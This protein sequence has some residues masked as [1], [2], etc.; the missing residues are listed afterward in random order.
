MI[1]GSVLSGQEISFFAFLHLPLRVYPCIVVSALF[2]SS[3]LNFCVFWRAAM[4]LV[5]TEISF[6][7]RTAILV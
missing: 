5:K 4:W 2:R 3:S 1:F 7:C 6:L